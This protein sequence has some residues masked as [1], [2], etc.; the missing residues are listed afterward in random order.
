MTLRSLDEPNHAAG[1]KDAMTPP[2]SPLTPQDHQH[3]LVTV[4]GQERQPHA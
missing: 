1:R 3:L 4:L 2:S